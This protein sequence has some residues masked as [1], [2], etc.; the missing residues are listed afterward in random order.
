MQ[1]FFFTNSPRRPKPQPWRRADAPRSPW[2]AVGAGAHSPLPCR[3]GW[4]SL[5]SQWPL[6]GTS[7]I[8][9]CSLRSF[10]EHPGCH[11]GP[12]VV[13]AAVGPVLA[14]LL[15]QAAGLGLWPEGKGRA[16]ALFSATCTARGVS[17]C[18]VSRSLGPPSLSPKAALCRW[19]EVETSVLLGPWEHAGTWCHVC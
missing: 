9:H 2:A 16:T 1:P 12:E 19:S 11:W 14:L 7:V 17:L 18:W 6:L 4:L 5:M 8:S 3:A 15:S 10:P 13:A